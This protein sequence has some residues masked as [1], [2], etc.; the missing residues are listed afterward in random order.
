[1]ATLASFRRWCG[2]W[3]R[4]WRDCPWPFRCRDRAGHRGDAGPRDRPAP[5]GGWIGPGRGRPDRP[6]AAD[7]R[8]RRARR[9]AQIWG[10]M[11]LAGQVIWA[12][13]FT[14]T[15]RRRRAGQ[16]RAEAQGQRVQLFGQ[17]GDRAVRGRDPARRPDLGRWQ[18]NF[19]TRPEPAGLFRQRRPA[20]RPARSRRSRAPERRRP[21]A[22][23]PM[24]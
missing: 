8:G 22:A 10:R 13:E 14:E 7:R 6:A 19:A 21:I 17:P 18:R 20:A 9:S 12:T 2:H 3:G 24:S 5:A 16:G 23:W 15:V 1:M 4:V 11:R